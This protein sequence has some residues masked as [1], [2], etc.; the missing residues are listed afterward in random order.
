MKKKVEMSRFF[1]AAVALF[2]FGIVAKVTYA[3]DNDNVSKKIGC[4]WS[5]PG[6]TETYD[7][8]NMKYSRYYNARFKFQ[9]ELPSSWHFDGLPPAN[10]DGRKFTNGKDIHLSVY[11][12]HYMPDF[13]LSV[14]YDEDINDP[15]NEITYMRPEDTYYILSGTLK[16]TDL[17]FYKKMVLSKKGDVVRTLYVTY[18]KAQLEPLRSVVEH[19]CKS[20][21]E[22]SD[23]SATND[24]L[25][26]LASSSL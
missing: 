10:K 14:R 1:V 6:R 23:R 4:E 12:S 7:K 11:A 8:A 24:Q 2:L 26:P 18:P 21:I 13:S 9:L 20:F 22:K 19:M 25:I 5:T 3:S 15:N 16:G 17:I